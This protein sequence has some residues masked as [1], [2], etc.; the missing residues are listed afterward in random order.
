MTFFLVFSGKGLSLKPDEMVPLQ[1]LKKQAK[2]VKK[3]FDL[4]TE[5]SLQLFT[6]L[7]DGARAI[8]VFENKAADC[9]QLDLV[10]RS[11]HMRKDVLL[12][13]GMFEFWLEQDHKPVFVFRP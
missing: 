4:V 6:E 7:S 2:P 12:K 13:K 11:F 9:I 10:M 3:R 5:L 1:L 8:T